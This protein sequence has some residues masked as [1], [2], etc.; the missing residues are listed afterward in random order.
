MQRKAWFF[1]VAILAGLATSAAHAQSTEYT[2]PPKTTADLVALCTQR[3]NDPRADA[4]IAYCYGFAEGAIDIVL[5][6]A[7]VGKP[8]QRPICVPSPAPPL[9]Q[10]MADFVAWAGKDSANLQKPAAVGLV[11]YLVTHFACPKTNDRR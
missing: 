6:Y 8:S 4:A 11:S 5:S 3:S 2:V 10:V 1:G 7:A 9:S